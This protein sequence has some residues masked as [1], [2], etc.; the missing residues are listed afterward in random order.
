MMEG[1]ES[2]FAWSNEVIIS[3]MIDS[4]KFFT[5]MTKM[6]NLIKYLLVDECKDFKAKALNQPRRI[7]FYLTIS[8]T[9]NML[10]WITR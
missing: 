2:A 1:I 7:S 5:S 10:Y 6:R 9:I 3:I 8:T 4:V